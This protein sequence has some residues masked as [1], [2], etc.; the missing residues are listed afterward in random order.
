MR[1]MSLGDEQ[2]DFGA[3]N[4]KYTCDIRMP[5]VEFS[6][7]CRD[8]SQFGEHMVIECKQG[9]KHLSINLSAWQI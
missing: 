7:I 6:R 8:L 4:E 9:G 2:D 1:L 3:L 5:S